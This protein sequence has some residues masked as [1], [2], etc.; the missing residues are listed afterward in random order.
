MSIALAIHRFCFFK[1]SITGFLRLPIAIAYSFN[2]ISLIL[3]LTKYLSGSSQ[4]V[5]PTPTG[6]PQYVER[7]FSLKGTPFEERL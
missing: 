1:L 4:A 3:F 5:T 2:R 6:I 7:Y